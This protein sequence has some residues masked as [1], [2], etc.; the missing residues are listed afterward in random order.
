MEYWEP[1]PAATW[2]IAE[3]FALFAE[4]PDVATKQN[5]RR[6]RQRGGVHHDVHSSVQLAGLKRD[7][8]P[9]RL[10]GQGDVVGLGGSSLN[11]PAAGHLPFV[12]TGDFLRLIAGVNR[13]LQ[14]GQVASPRR[15]R[16]ARRIPSVRERERISA[17]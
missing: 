12:A 4:G 11:R 1:R 8:P 2:A 14:D 5:R 6:F 7:H 10:L 16:V 13:L 17:E 9:G 3:G 15:E